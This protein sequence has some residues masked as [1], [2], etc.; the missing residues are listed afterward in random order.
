M[1]L[2]LFVEWKWDW[3]DCALETVW[4]C[5]Y[6]WKFSFDEWC[7]HKRAA[8]LEFGF[9]LKEIADWDDSK[10]ALIDCIKYLAGTEAVI[11]T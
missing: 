8:T 4:L 11:P 9:G 1:L 3:F 7:G 10:L 5:W 2:I 6:K